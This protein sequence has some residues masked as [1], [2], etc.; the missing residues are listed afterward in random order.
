MPTG[1]YVSAGLMQLRG[2]ILNLYDAS[3]TDPKAFNGDAEEYGLRMEE[4]DPPLDRMAK[5][6]AY[7]SKRDGDGSRLPSF[8]ED[9]AFSLEAAGAKYAGSPV[10]DLYEKLK[11]QWRVTADILEFHEK[12]PSGTYRVTLHRFSEDGALEPLKDI[13]IAG[14]GFMEVLGTHGYPVSTQKRKCQIQN[15]LDISGLSEQDTTGY[16]YIGNEPSE[17]EERIVLC[18]PGWSGDGLLDAGVH[19]G[20]SYSD[21]GVAALRIRSP[22]PGDYEAEIRNLKQVAEG[23]RT[24]I[25][26]AR[27][28]LKDI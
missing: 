15:T 18:G 1:L 16:W 2:R 9:I 10:A 21:E 28:T 14:G 7:L 19:V 22:T 12:L 13:N 6:A 11:T 26:T 23:I 25:K 27:E 24:K 8:P 3:R 5:V 17:G 4:N 20:R